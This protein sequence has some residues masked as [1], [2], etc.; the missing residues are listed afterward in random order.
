MTIKET[1]CL[2]LLIGVIIFSTI[3]HIH[4][5]DR[6]AM[7]SAWFWVGF[8]AVWIFWSALITALVNNKIEIE[9]LKKDVDRVGEKM[10]KFLK[11]E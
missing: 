3:L 9:R 7:K 4:K 11:Q 10:D 5:D 6:L 8:L 1:L 2:I